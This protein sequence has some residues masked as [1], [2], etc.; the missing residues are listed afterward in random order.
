MH[1]FKIYASLVAA[2]LIAIIIAQNTAVVE[3]KVLFVTIAMPRAALLAVTLLSGVVIGFVLALN[4]GRKK[5]P[6]EP[7]EPTD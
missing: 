6:T 1:K 7:S 4:W 5:K 2:V 3:T